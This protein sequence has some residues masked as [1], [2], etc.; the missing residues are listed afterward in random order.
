MKKIVVFLSMVAV[1][2]MS[3]GVISAHHGSRASYD[4]SKQ[5]VMTGVV[6]EFIWQNPHIYILYDV[7]DDNNGTV[8][9]W[10]AETNSPIVMIR[11]GW[12]RNELKQGDKIIVTVFPSKAG[13]PRGYLAKLVGPD[14]KV[15]D[16]TARVLD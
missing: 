5:V 12:T 9:H 14:G 3:S 15:T 2:L 7:K 10:G 6:T 13:G 16:L 11:D 4:M 1:F 8:T